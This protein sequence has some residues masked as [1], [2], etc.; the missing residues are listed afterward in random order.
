M[1]MASLPCT[2]CRELRHT[3]S[4]PNRMN[5]NRRDR[6]AGPGES[7]VAEEPEIHQRIGSSTQPHQQQR[8]QSQ[9]AH[10]GYVPVPSGR[11]SRRS[12]LDDAVHERRD[13]HERQSGADEVEPLR[14][15]I[16]G[17]RDEQYDPDDGQDDN[18]DGR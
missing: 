14:V 10:H 16:T 17:L 7:G 2:C 13:T 4:T 9:A 6:D 18:R 8:Q 1:F 15:R 3:N 5:I 11:S 12:D